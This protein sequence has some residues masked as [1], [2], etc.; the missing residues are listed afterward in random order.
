MCSAVEGASLSA[1]NGQRSVD[2]LK[3][4]ETLVTERVGCF[5]LSCWRVIRP[6]FHER[7]C[8]LFKSTGTQ[9]SRIATREMEEDICEH[10]LNSWFCARPNARL[11]QRQRVDLTGA[12]SLASQ[13]EDLKIA[14]SALTELLKAFPDHYHTASAARFIAA[15]EERPQ[16]GGSRLVLAGFF[17]TIANTWR[18]LAERSICDRWCN[19]AM[20]LFQDEA[21]WSKDGFRSG[22]VRMDA[23]WLRSCGDAALRQLRRERACWPRMRQTIRIGSGLR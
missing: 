14:C 17:R 7:G 23:H 2:R 5:A 9:G 19:T 10:L 4:I 16:R 18:V 8:L 12:L 1:E 20:K 22:P 13:S 11:L 3:S 6:T 15:L 21:W